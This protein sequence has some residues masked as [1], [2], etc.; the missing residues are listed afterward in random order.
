MLIEKNH[1][2]INISE[3]IDGHLFT[4]R[5]IGYTR[6]EAVREFKIERREAANPYKGR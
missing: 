4:R 2:C 3:T 1:A 5:Y 6:K